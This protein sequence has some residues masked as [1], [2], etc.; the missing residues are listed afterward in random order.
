MVNKNTFGAKVV[1][2]RKAAPTKRSNMRMWP[3]IGEVSNIGRIHV[4]TYI[5]ISVYCI[6]SIPVG[7]YIC[8]CLLR[9]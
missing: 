4:E 7:T 2:S 5:L 9:Y 8:T 6:F 3:R 1:W